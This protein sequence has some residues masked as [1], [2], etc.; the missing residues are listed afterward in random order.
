M[1]F[2]KVCFLLQLLPLGRQGRDRRINY[3]VKCCTINLDDRGYKRGKL[4]AREKAVFLS[5]LLRLFINDAFFHRQHEVDRSPDAVT[6]DLVRQTYF[7]LR[8]FLSLV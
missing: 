1:C 4:L 2:N 3:F 6:Q 5:A 8:S 7:A